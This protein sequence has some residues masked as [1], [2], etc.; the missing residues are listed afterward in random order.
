MLLQLQ[1]YELV[2]NVS[3]LLCW[4]MVAY[5]STQSG[6]SIGMYPQVVG[7]CD[8]VPLGL[9]VKYPRD[10]IVALLHH[11][12]DVSIDGVHIWR[13]LGWDVG[14]CGVLWSHS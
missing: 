12:L 14:I 3:L 1:Y 7:S 9:A 8:F 2:L 6:H 4:W 11:N 13:A 5:H 10:L